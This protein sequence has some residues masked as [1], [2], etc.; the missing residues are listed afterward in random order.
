MFFHNRPENR[1]MDSTAAFTDEVLG[2]IYCHT[3]PRA[4]NFIVRIKDGQIHVTAPQTASMKQL[5]DM[6]R[7][8]REKIIRMKERS[9]NAAEREKGYISGSEV[10]SSHWL[11]VRLQQHGSTRWIL[12]KNGTAFTIYHPAEADLSQPQ[13]NELIKRTILNC[14]KT[15]A[16]ETLPSRLSQLA[17]RHGFAYSSVKISSAQT[18][19]GSCSSQ[20][21]I[22]LSA[23][24][25]KLP[26][27]LVDYVLLH[28][29]CHT[30]EMNHSPRFWALMDS[31]TGNM[32]HS[33]RAETRR[34][35]T[36]L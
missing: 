22:S 14:M 7:A 35:S 28:E 4:K 36:S 10:F 5:K 32:A 33:L 9:G 27:H 25:M 19:W 11:T 12:S 6:L 23:Y 29:L 34:Y 13:E 1:D 17:A 21:A 15:V 8:N 16:R 18:R 24:L 20:R 30:V 2:T 3:N 26:P 31:V